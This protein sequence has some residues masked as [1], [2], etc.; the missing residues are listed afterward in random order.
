MAK[1]TGPQGYYRFVVIFTWPGQEDKHLVKWVADHNE[2]LGHGP[3]EGT[4]IDPGS[5][6]GYYLVGERTAIVIAFAKSEKDI[7]KFCKSVIRN[8]DVKAK[9]CHAI[10]WQEIKDYAPDA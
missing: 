5:A 6:H 2:N 1:V 4:E 8:H 10:D 3:F 7:Q 9:I